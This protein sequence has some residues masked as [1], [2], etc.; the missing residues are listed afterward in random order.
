VDP[1]GKVDFPADQ[2]SKYLLTFAA[3]AT[4]S[5]VADCN[6]LVGTYKT[7]DP[8]KPSGDLTLTPGPFTAAACPPGSFSDLYVYALARSKSYAIDPTT[9]LL[10]ITLTDGGTAIFEAGKAAP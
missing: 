6:K 10:T 7:A 8:T 5:A 1:A 4:F 3:D 9:K 2:R